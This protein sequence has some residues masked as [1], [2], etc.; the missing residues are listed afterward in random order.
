[1]NTMKRLNLVLG[2][3]AC[4]S[5]SPSLSLQRKYWRSPS[6]G[7]LLPPSMAG[8][9]PFTGDV[10]IKGLEF[11]LDRRMAIPSPTPILFHGHYEG[12]KGR[13]GIMVDGNGCPIGKR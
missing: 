11:D 4:S 10:K 2:L 9:R 5:S 8:C 1:M 6:I 3:L 12:F 13:W 7:N